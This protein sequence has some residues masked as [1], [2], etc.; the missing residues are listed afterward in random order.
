MLVRTDRN[1]L[2]ELSLS[3]YDA[4]VLV[5]GAE[6]E[7]FVDPA[8]W[9]RGVDILAVDCGGFQG[10]GA[11]YES[12]LEDCGF[13]PAEFFPSLTGAADG[14]QPELIAIIAHNRAS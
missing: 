1:G 10:V 8:R 14:W 13:E 7:I 9:F 3:D 5:E 6:A 4:I 11:V 2:T 12:L